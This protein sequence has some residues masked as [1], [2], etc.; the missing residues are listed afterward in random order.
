MFLY[1]FYVQTHESR[2]T[3]AYVLN[4][5]LEKN[6]YLSDYYKEILSIS[7]HW[8]SINYKFLLNYLTIYKHKFKSLDHLLKYLYPNLK[9]IFYYPHNTWNIYFT[10]LLSL[11]NYKKII[12]LDDIHSDNYSKKVNFH[13]CNSFDKIFCSYDYKVSKLRSEIDITKV[14]PF[15]HYVSNHLVIDKQKIQFLKKKGIVLSGF[16]EPWRSEFYTIRHQLYLKYSDQLINLKKDDNIFGYKFYNFI[17]TSLAAIS[18]PGNIGYIVAKYFE[19]PSSYTLLLAYD[20][21]IESHLQN[22]GFIDNIN[23][24]SFNMNNVQD[25]IDFIKNPKNI[26]KIREITENG[27]DLIISKHLLTNRVVLLDNICNELIS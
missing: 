21:N 2:N 22:L 26:D 10:K 8:N 5:S 19:I 24:I 23:Y 15:P 18:T 12:Y 16:D 7:K 20:E 27:Y 1:I 14:V 11:S 4:N 25:K 13:F 9:V 3:L 17:N 6:S